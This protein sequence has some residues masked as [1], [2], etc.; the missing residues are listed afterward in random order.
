[1]QHSDFKIGDVFWCGD[2]RWR[3]TDIGTRTI[4]AIPAEN[5]EV[6]NAGQK[7]RLTYDEAQAEGWLNGPPYAVAECVF[8]EDD[9]EACS[10]QGC[11]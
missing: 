4:V 5:I 8:G 3:C 10:A 2:Y 6:V 1:M 11:R 7:R 9:I